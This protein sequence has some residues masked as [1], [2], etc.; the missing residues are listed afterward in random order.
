MMIRYC[1]FVWSFKILSYERMLLETLL[2]F[3]LK[4][5]RVNRICQIEVSLVFKTKCKDQ[6]EKDLRVWTVIMIVIGINRK[7]QWPACR[8]YNLCLTQV[9]TS[10][11]HDCDTRHG[12]STR[13]DVWETLERRLQQ[14][15]GLIIS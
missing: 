12:D 9:F 1:Y 6:L 8:L 11:H 14:N 4:L 7:G 3:D 10:T 2:L 5:V 15:S 13:L